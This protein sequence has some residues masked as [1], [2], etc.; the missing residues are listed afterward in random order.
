[1]AY[2]VK[3]SQVDQFD[4]DG[5]TC[6]ESHPVKVPQVMYEVQWDV[7]G[8]GVGR[9]L[10]CADDGRRRSSMIGRCGPRMGRSR[11][12]GV[13][14]I[15]ECPWEGGGAVVTVA[16]RVQTRLFTTWRLCVS[17]VILKLLHS[18]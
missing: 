13:R 7:S 2:P 16:D 6:P 9:G 4:Y 8:L 17:E 18:D 15:S 14:G 11:L 3:G 5:G 10:G 1:M 12:F